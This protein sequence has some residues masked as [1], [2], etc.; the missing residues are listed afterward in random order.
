MPDP[1]QCQTRARPCPASC[2]RPSARPCAR[3]RPCPHAR[4]RPA[5]SQTLCLTRPLSQTPC[6]PPPRP[7]PDPLPAPS[8]PVPSVVPAVPA[9]TE[10]FA[11]PPFGRPTP[12][13]PYKAPP[14]AAPNL[15]PYNSAAHNHHPRPPPP[16]PRPRPRPPP[17]PAP[18]RTRGPRRPY[19]TPRPYRPAAR[20]TA[21]PR[22]VTKYTSYRPYRPATSHFHYRSRGPRTSSRT[23]ARA[24]PTAR[25]RRP[26]GLRASASPA[27]SPPFSFHKPTSYKAP[28][29]T[30]RAPYKASGPSFVA[31]SINH[32]PA[33][34]APR[35]TLA[36]YHRPSPGYKPY[37]PTS[38]KP[39][40]K[41]S[42]TAASHKPSGPTKPVLAPL[43]IPV[44]QSGLIL[45]E[46]PR[47]GPF[48]VW[49]H[50]PG[51]ELP[52]PPPFR[53]PHAS[54]D[55]APAKGERRQRLQ[56]PDSVVRLL[57]SPQPD[58]VSSLEPARR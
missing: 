23:A 3:P 42:T 30:T 31:Y 58:W 5:L 53:L 35:P 55:D 8:T 13:Q 7:L 47:E 20:P 26:T 28:R 18:S 12:F 1:A 25:P 14:R 51:S 56:V 36:P 9:P 16:R 43:S 27:T 19:T 6:R 21:H 17:P 46:T 34:K 15:P 49:A 39:Y 29:T 33:T 24:P 2:T 4:P 37:K 45:P 57:N 22:P 11:T 41:P 40:G 44:R 52:R 32:A 38:P 54:L 10:A 48:N 50:G